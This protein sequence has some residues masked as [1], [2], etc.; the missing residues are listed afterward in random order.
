MKVFGIDYFFLRD[1]IALPLLRSENRFVLFAANVSV[2]IIAWPNKFDPQT[3]LDS[4]PDVLAAK[5]NPT[6]HA[7]IM[8]VREGRLTSAGPMDCSSGGLKHDRAKKNILVVSHEASRTGAPIVALGLIRELGQKYNVITLLLGGGEL[9][10]DF[11]ANSV[12]LYRDYVARRSDLGFQ[13][14]LI[15]VLRKHAPEFAIV[16]SLESRVSFRPISLT[17]IPAIGLIHEYASYTKPTAGVVTAL[18][19]SDLWIFSSALTRQDSESVIGPLVMEKSSVI[20][21][22]Q[23][24]TAYEINAKQKV[25]KALFRSSSDDDTDVV[26]ILGAGYV[27]YRKGVDLFIECARQL[28]VQ[29]P[30]IQFEFVWLG[31]GFRPETDMGY[32]VYLQDQIQRAGLS[33]KLKILDAREDFLE[34]LTEANVFLLTSRLDPL[35]NVVIDALCEG[36]PTLTFDKAS[37]FPEIFRNW[38]LEKHLVAEFLDVQG[39]TKLVLNLIGS[40]SEHISLSSEI[41]SLALGEFS[42]AKYAKKIE[43]LAL[44][45][46]RTKSN[47]DDK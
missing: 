46:K 39:M 33:G 12:L 28:V 29:A 47:V 1:K 10:H 7:L 16:N 17:G 9:E 25:D 30:D 24:R 37:G 13:A 43:R 21:Q 14:K 23:V 19:N 44:E 20:P 42:F 45:I 6:L 41:K 15:K 38:G 36:I 35:P 34:V 5:L 27:Q 2:K 40:E 18:K 32:S 22:G 26:R 4:N 8:G 31:D 11:R 3:Y